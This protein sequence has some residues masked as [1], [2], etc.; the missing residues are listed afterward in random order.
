MCYKMNEPWNIIQMTEVSYKTTYFMILFNQISI[1]SKSI[2]TENGL[3][4]DYS[5]GEKY[6]GTGGDN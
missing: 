1:V 5:W 2:V 6:L 3:V 4:V